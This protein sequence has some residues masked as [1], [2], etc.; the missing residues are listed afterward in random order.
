MRIPPE[1]ESLLWTILFVRFHQDLTCGTLCND[2]F[3]SVFPKVCCRRLPKGAISKCNIV[4]EPLHE[5][6]CSVPSLHP[7][8]KIAFKY[9]KRARQ[10]GSSSL[11]GFRGDPN[12][13]VAD[14]WMSSVLCEKVSICLFIIH[15]FPYAEPAVFVGTSQN[16]I[17][18]NCQRAHL[19]TSSA[20]CERKA[21]AMAIRFSEPPG[22][23]SEVFDSL[24]PKAHKTS[25][26]WSQAF[27]CVY[28][29]CSASHGR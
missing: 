25:S 4:Y 12:T 22:L 13:V 8:E 16:T 29:Y 23:D 26:D 27:S 20:L 17:A 10:A 28:R 19:L 6:G 1:F 11:R 21:S 18:A 3:R 9:L 24:W 2:V 15:V 7:L 14:G 5:M